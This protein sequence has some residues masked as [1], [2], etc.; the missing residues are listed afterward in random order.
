MNSFLNQTYDLEIRSIP[1]FTFKVKD[2]QTINFGLDYRLNS[3][4]NNK[5]PKGVFW[6]FLKY[7]ILL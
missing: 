7:D 4:I 3:F 2:Y 6:F 1:S 5:I